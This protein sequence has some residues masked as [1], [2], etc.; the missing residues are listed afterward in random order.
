MSV[1]PG[2]FSGMSGDKDAKVTVPSMKLGTE[3]LTN[4]DPLVGRVA[5]E[6]A[7]NILNSAIDY[8]TRR[9]VLPCVGITEHVL[10]PPPPNAANAYQAPRGVSSFSGTGLDSVGY[11]NDYPELRP[12]SSIN[13]GQPSK[14]GM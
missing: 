6:K 10:R 4:R 2:I 9:G 3:Q 5:Y 12:F 7:P 1:V 13:M 14:L 11:K 8:S